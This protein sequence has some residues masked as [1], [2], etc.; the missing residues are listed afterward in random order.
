M[1]NAM[2]TNSFGQNLTGV[3]FNSQTVA[4]SSQS[5]SLVNPTTVDID[6]IRENVVDIAGPKTP[7]LDVKE[8]MKDV[9]SP[10]QSEF[11]FVENSFKPLT[12][13]P[14]NQ[15]FSFPSTQ[16]PQQS[17]NSSP[18]SGFGGF[19]GVDPQKNITPTNNIASS[20]PG[21]PFNL[22][23]LNT[24]KK[25]VTV[26]IN[27]IKD[28]VKNIETKGYNVSVEETDSGDSYQIIIKVNKNV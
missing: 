18:S 25:D 11:K 7:A 9:S 16:A 14:S 26:A 17:A 19:F 15:S 24:A 13:S 5:V 8:L 23:S 4:D 22:T 20:I 10:T 28:T 27:D 21:N 3:G 1:G 6:K 2:N 12:E